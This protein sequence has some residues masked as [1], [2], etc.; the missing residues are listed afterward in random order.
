MVPQSVQPNNR[1][2]ICHKLEQVTVNDRRTLSP[3]EYLQS[4]SP[5]LQLRQTGLVWSHLTRR[6]T[7]VRQPFER[8]TPTMVTVGPA[9]ESG[10]HLLGRMMHAC[11]WS[12][13]VMQFSRSEEAR[14]H[15]MQVMEWQAT[16]VEEGLEPEKSKALGFAVRCRHQHF[17]QST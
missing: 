9:C 15:E 7:Q 16:R 2:G 4:R 5:F 10:I 11:V 8:G 12:H 6:C 17:S 13:L 14:A 1:H 3:S